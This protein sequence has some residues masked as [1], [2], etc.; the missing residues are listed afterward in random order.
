MTYSIVN[1]TPPLSTSTWASPPTAIVLHATA[2][3]TGRSSVDYL[4]S[5]GLSYHYII[6]RDGKDTSNSSN[7][8]GTPPIV[9]ACVPL[10][11]RAAHVG[12]NI[13]FPN[14]GGR[15]ANRCAIGVSLAN[16][17][18]G[19]AYTQPQLDALSSVIASIVGAV[20]TI[21]VLTTHAVIQP[22]NRRDPIGVDGQTLAA[23]HGLSWFQPTPAE[24]QQY[25]PIKQGK[26]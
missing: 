15:I 24:I 23:Q 11:N 14:S 12:S 13:P 10:S 3:A 22:W 7:A 19:E 1:V 8:D 17:Q 2:G 16:R 21:K 9:Y 20:P 4:R 25:K 6:A 26:S 18:N 5:V